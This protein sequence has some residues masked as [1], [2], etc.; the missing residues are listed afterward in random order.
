MGNISYRR[1]VPLWALAIT[2]LVSLDLGLGCFKRGDPQAFYEHARATF[3][4]G[5][6]ADGQKEAE[7]GYQRF[8]RS[9][10][11]WAW[12]FRTLEAEVLLWRGMYPDV[13]K[14]LDAEPDGK[15]LKIEVLALRG[16]AHA[17]LHQFSEAEQ[18]LDGAGR[19]CAETADSHCGDVIRAR[20]LLAN[21]RGQRDLARELFRQSLSFARTRDDQ[22]LG[23]TALL[24]LGA[25]SLK[26][27]RFDEAMEWSGAAYQAAERLNAD[28]IAQTALGNVGWARYRLG[29]SEGALAAFLQAKERATKLG[30]YID[31]ASWG[32]DAGYVYSDLRDFRRARESYLL[33][34][35][36]ARRWGAKEAMFNGLR[37][38][39]RLS[40]ATNDFVGGGEYSRQA[41]DIAHASGIPADELYPMLV[42]GQIAAR[43]GNALMA[44]QIFEG[45]ERDP[46]CP[47]FLKWEAQ[48]SLAR[49]FADQKDPVAANRKYRAALDTFESARATVRREDFQLSFLT[50]AA[51]IYDDYLDFLVKVGRTAEALQWADYSRA[52]TLSEGLGLLSKERAGRGADQ[53]RAAAPKLNPQSI[54]RRANG[55]ILFYWLGEKQSYLWAITAQQTRLFTLPSGREIEAAVKR[56]RA[57]LSGPAN[58]LESSTDGTELYRILVA[59]AQ[60]FLRKDSRVFIIPDGELNNLNFETLVASSPAPHYWIEDVDVI[61]SPSLRILA[62]SL[63]EKDRTPS[64]LLLIGDSAS[65][66]TDY[67][68][69]PKA[70]DQMGTVER[71]FGGAHRLVYQR[72]HATPSAYLNSSPGQFSYI[73]FVAHGT[74][75]RVD[76]LDSA[77]VL[78]KEPD[79]PDS[80]KLY[81][82]DITQHRIRAELVT[83]SACYSAGDRH[84]SGEGMVGLAWA[85]LRAGARNVVAALWEVTDV[86]TDQL[87]DRFYDELSKGATPDAALR[88]AKLA[89]LKGGRFRSPFYWAPMQLFRG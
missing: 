63:H 5:N 38:L 55:T 41:L 3:V 9:N 45:V 62:A 12:R 29:D 36:L 24:N 64:K 82:R 58:V 75:S 17:R 80:F 81:A 44:R 65:P 46:A 27:E 71:H 16:A 83:I 26:Q 68:E 39:A 7:V 52:R 15:A 67:P 6:L 57:A 1:P 53:I 51:G 11:Q 59:P 43:R 40:L 34:L 28:D 13:L 37:A 84:Y 21:Q 32:M 22:F 2:L 74:A 72:E 33:A 79:N 56:Y 49:L 42:E 54:A 60:S 70:A 14:Q 10:P 35:D 85:F 86:S 48:H 73:H 78:S 25:V 19:L 69:L 18:E 66:G 4:R 61:N 20:G 30:D 77:I 88:A 76:P 23:A 87:M 8:R 31:E 47:V 89:L 50:N